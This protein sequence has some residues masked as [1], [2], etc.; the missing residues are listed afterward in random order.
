MAETSPTVTR[1][2]PPCAAVG[3]GR[4]VVFAPAILVR[5]KKLA[6]ASFTF[7]VWKFEPRSRVHRP[8][9]RLPPV[10]HCDA[11]QTQALPL[12]RYIPGL[13]SFSEGAMRLA[14]AVPARRLDRY[15]QDS[16]HLASFD[17]N[18]GDPRLSWWAF[19][20]GL[21]SV[22]LCATG[23]G[24]NIPEQPASPRRHRFVRGAPPSL[25]PPWRRFHE[26]SDR[27]IPQ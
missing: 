24:A 2:A 14:F 20:S 9:R 22:P 26:V 17:I 8:A 12:N 23:H 7:A 4:K 19:R 10:I 15:F 27:C 11:L 25:R 13:S 21:R 18:S 1:A 16:S 3:G 6:S 5:P